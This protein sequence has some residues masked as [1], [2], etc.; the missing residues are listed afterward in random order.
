MI[1]Y[2][3]RRLLQGAV[4]LFIVSLLTFTVMYFMPGDPAR[5]MVGQA[6]VTEEQLE[7]IRERWHL[8]DSYPERY[9]YWLSNLL[10]GDLGTSMMM[11]GF[12]IGDLILDRAGWT[13]RLTALSAVIS[14][15][16]AIPLGVLAAVRRYSFVDY[17]STLISTLGVAIPN[18]FIG[19]ILIVVFAGKL[20]WLPPFGATSW[21]HYLM[22]VGVLAFGEM[23]GIARLTR[24]ATIEVLSQDYIK[25][26]HAKGL[27]MK[28]VIL[29]HVLRNALLP[30]IT[31]IGYRMAFILSGTIV[32]ETVFSWPGLGQLFY[33]AITFK[34]LQLVQA[35]VLLLTG[36]VVIMN[37]VTDLTYGFIDPR[38]RLK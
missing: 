9:W 28:V 5:V 11:P 24:G 18:Y 25:T 33:D 29:R 19:I 32:I 37:I 14:I 4:V 13:I 30:I 22:P 35:I 27:A 15:G 1:S 31:L 12:P 38:V 10:K 36:I 20:G 7:A 26:A 3:I 17:L 34:D 21:K 6:R 2:V 16:L 8:N 23:A